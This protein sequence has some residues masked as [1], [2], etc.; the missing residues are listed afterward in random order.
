[1]NRATNAVL[2]PTILQAMVRAVT[3]S[4]TLADVAK[5]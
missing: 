5:P 2:Y 4:Y 1:M 3:S